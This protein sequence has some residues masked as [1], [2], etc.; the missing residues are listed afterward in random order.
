MSYH[1]AAY[2][3]EPPAQFPSSTPD[4]FK[5]SRPARELETPM[6]DGV[7]LRSDLYMP[8]NCDRAPAILIRQPYGRATPAM[9]FAQTGS[10]WARKGYACVVQDVRGKFSSDGIFDPMVHEAHD[11]HDTVDWVSRQP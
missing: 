10:F 11:G 2:H 5:T 6:R 7:V 8:E 9:A 4:R 1:P 3:A